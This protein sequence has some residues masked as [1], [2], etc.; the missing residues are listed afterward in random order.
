MPLYVSARK[1]VYPKKTNVIMRTIIQ[2][3]LILTGLFSYLSFGQSGQGW[4]SD[5]SKPK[6]F[7]E[8]KGQYNEPAKLINMSQVEFACDQSS[9]MY[10][11]TKSGMTIELSNKHKVIKSEQEKAE[12][13]QRKTEPFNTLQEWQEFENKGN[14]ITFNRDVLS[15]TWVGSNPNVELVA[16][17]ANTFYHSFLINTDAGTQENVTNIKSYNK[18]TYKNLYNNIDV[19]YEFHPDGGVKYSVIVFPGG[20]ISQIK[21]QYSKDT[22]LLPDGTIRTNTAYGEIIDHAPL[23]FYQNNTGTVIKSAYELNDNIISFKLDNFDATKTIII[24]PWTQ[25]PAFATNWD[26]IWE[27]ETDAAG[28]VYVIG[29]VMPLQLKV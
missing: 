1:F 22:K 24:D 25:A 20:D 8:N 14:R 21:L 12:R 11:F 9:Q 4:L 17:N 15:C 6:S 2:L 29:G 7:I 16:E 18:L 26:C 10:F 28:N 27:T 13:E 19:V 5:Y 23:T 3:F